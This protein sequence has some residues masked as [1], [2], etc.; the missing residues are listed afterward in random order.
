VAVSFIFPKTATPTAANKAGLRRTEFKIGGRE[1]LPWITVLPPILNSVR[2][3]PPP[4]A[5]PSNENVEPYKPRQVVIVFTND[6]ASGQ[7]IGYYGTILRVLAA[8]V[9]QNPARP[10]RWMYRVYLPYL[11]K[12]LDLE[13]RDLCVTESIDPNELPAEPACEIRFSSTIDLD[14]REIH[15]AYRVPSRDWDYFLFQKCDEA[16]SSFQLRL[17]I[18]AGHGTLYY[19]VPATIRLDCDYVLHAIAEI[20]GIRE[21]QQS[22]GAS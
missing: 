4:M 9:S 11:K 13:A 6:L 15:G 14:N 17:P 5:S 12:Y 21:W 10:D 18:G 1:F 8:T 22:K 2:L 20:L 16:N 3:S 7:T 19:N